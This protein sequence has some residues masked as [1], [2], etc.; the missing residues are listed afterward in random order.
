MVILT[1]WRIIRNEFTVLLRIVSKYDFIE[2]ST[3][4]TYLEPIEVKKAKKKNYVRIVPKYDFNAF[5]L[6]VHILNSL[7][8]RTSNRL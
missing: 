5:E 4:L 1:P 8:T 3:F 7:Y 6:D 2:F